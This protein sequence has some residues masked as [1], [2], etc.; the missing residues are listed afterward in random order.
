MRLV[1][2]LL[3]I[4]CGA[5]LAAGAMSAASYAAQGEPGEHHYH[6]TAEDRAALL[7]SS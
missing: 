5:A 2:H 3:I 1:K 6:A 7:D 4:A